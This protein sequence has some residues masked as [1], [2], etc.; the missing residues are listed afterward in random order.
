M[1]LHKCKHEEG[2]RS[3]QALLGA[4]TDVSL[5]IDHLTKC[6]VHKTLFVE[7]LSNHSQCFGAQI[8]FFFQVLLFAT[9]NYIL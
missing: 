1:F 4:V 3:C 9:N 8:S 7:Q 2:L 6:S 5:V